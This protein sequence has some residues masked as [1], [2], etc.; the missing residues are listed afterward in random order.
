MTAWGVPALKS[1]HSHH[2]QYFCSPYLA[3]HTSERNVVVMLYCLSGRSQLLL[4]CSLNIH[5]V[6][7]LRDKKWSHWGFWDLK[8]KFCQVND[9]TCSCDCIS[10][11]NAHHSQKGQPEINLHQSQEIFF[12]SRS[13]LSKSSITVHKL[14]AFVFA[15]LYGWKMLMYVTTVWYKHSCPYELISL[16]FR[17]HFYNLHLWLYHF[18]RDWQ[19][20]YWQMQCHIWEFVNVV[21]F[22][23]K[24]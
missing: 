22:N 1:L 11:A 5:R 15:K 18:T 17:H 14:L 8:E 21:R 20:I 3:V 2:A 10:A 12:S 7:P 13:L 23:G 6:P 4:V 24:K 9:A 19:Y 16:T